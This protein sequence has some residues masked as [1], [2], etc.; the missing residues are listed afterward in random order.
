[1]SAKDGKITITI[2][3]KHFDVKSGMT[4]LQA[5]EENGIYIPTLCSHKELTPHGGCRLCI[6]EVDGFRNFPT[7]CTT[8]VSDGMVIRTDTAA[9]NSIRHEIVQLF[10]SEHTSSCL[11]CPESEECRLWMGTVRK[12]GVTTGC[13]YCPND[14]QCEF[15]D[16]VQ[17]MGIKEIKYPIYYRNNR[18]EKEDPFYDRDY[19]LCILCGRCVRMC[20]EIRTANVLA[21]NF[22]G[23][24]TVIGPSFGR[25]HL[26][27]GC[28]FCG[29]CV[30]VCPTGALSE[31]DRKWEGKPDREEITTCSFCGVGCQMRLQVKENRIIG[32]LP[33]VGDIV[34]NGQLCVRGRFCISE[35]VNGHQRL[36]S[37]H[38]TVDGIDVDVSWD[39]AI[40]LAAEKLSACNPDEVDVLIS[41]NLTNEDLY[42]AQKFTRLALG[43]HN[44]DTSAR[45]F[46]GAGFNAYINLLKD[47]V[48]LS[49][50]RKASVILAVGLDSRFGRSVVGVE[51]RRAAKKG[52][53][54]L[55]IHPRQHSLGLIAEKWIQPLPSETVD[56]L[57]RLAQLTG[58]KAAVG[59]QAK[60][61]DDLTDV[62]RLLKDAEYAVILTGSEFLQ[63]DS[64]AR[65]HELVHEI[66]RNV[67]AGILPLPAQNNLVGSLMMGAY[68]EL[69]PAGYQ[70]TD[71]KG[72]AELQKL[73]GTALPPVRAG[74]NNGT[75]SGAKK[76][77]VLYLIGEAPPNGDISQAEFVIS[78]NIYAAEANRG[79]DLD[80][81]TAA[82]T[83]VDGT[84]VNGEGRVQRVRKAVDPKA[85]ALPDWEILCRL[86][87]KMGVRGFDYRSASDI[88]KEI[89]RLIPDFK[90]F[91]QPTRK[92]QPLVLK[93]HVHENGTKPARTAR[94]NGKEPFLLSACTVEHVHRGMPLST[95]VDGSRAI[96]REG[97]I[98]INP[99]DARKKRLDEGDE[100]I[101]S[102]GNF[103]RVWPVRLEPKQPRGTL[104]VIL[105]QGE[106]FNANPKAVSLRKKHV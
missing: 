2:D 32:S 69:L 46:Y 34:N 22:K 44:I 65:I 106:S 61:A 52:A 85:Q 102:S 83:E 80:L 96:F 58:K 42:V 76:L 82:F 104:F 27:A 50:V 20:Q 74:K 17:K 47:S 39:E 1:M 10:M 89:G 40:S 56:T 77:K 86:A 30:S 103:K 91:N 75:R 6:V 7:A 45:S 63:F 87:R 81:A 84:F 28:E 13:R 4:I 73:W 67:G 53:K 90:N 78:Q 5:S 51:L 11:I 41:P 25:T 79:V 99:V 57:E 15:Q 98:D 49:D 97:V 64:T 92:V 66:A 105:P 24:D 101:V 36:R 18:V 88:F 23:R 93:G 8:P 37:P 38:R 21:F 16:V 94:I 60:P 70:T 68:R 55:T 33:V 72:V 59:R 62:A 19:N 3:N 95:W 9:L 35:V 100:V 14:G 43:S 54:I 48:P 12:S 71:L 29:A 31:K 26:E